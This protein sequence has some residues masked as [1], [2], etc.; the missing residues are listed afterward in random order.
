MTG[1]DGVATCAY[2]V[3]VGAPL[4]DVPT[5]AAYAGSAD[6]DA[7]SDDATLTI[8]DVPV[9]AGLTIVPDHVRAGEKV[10][11]IYRDADLNDLTART[12]FTISYGA[13]GAWDVGSD[14]D[15]VYT[16]ARAGSWRV[17]AVYGAQT[18]AA[19]LTVDPNATL[20]P[21]SVS[22][23]PGEAWMTTAQTLTYTVTAKDPFG[24]PW[25]ASPEPGDWELDEVAGAFDDACLLTP[26]APSV[27]RLRCTV[28]GVL[29]NWA[30][31]MVIDPTGPGPFLA[32]DKDTCRFYLCANPTDPQTLEITG[33][34]AYD[35]GGQWV[36][37]TV[38]RGTRR[39]DG[40]CEQ[41]HVGQLAVVPAEELLRSY[42]Y[43]SLNGA[44]ASTWI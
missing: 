4:G 10:T 1:A 21:M 16:S 2:L 18:A 23:A 36:V 22:I 34:G 33:S 29:S 26:S 14:P 9:R 7:S 32:W 35:V 44:A 31:L 6:R 38:A 12:R 42:G 20:T 5:G 17:T 19:T 11:A 40:D 24:N 15:N 13:G 39:T 41:R 30:D 3:P 8:N 28:N 27:G 25:S 37:V 43:S